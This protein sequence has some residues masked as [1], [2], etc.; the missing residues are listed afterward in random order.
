MD[1]NFFLHEMSLM[2]VLWMSHRY[3]KQIMVI[4]KEHE[5]E[6]Y[7]SQAIENPNTVMYSRECGVLKHF[8]VPGMTSHVHL[9]KGDSMKVGNTFWP[10]LVM[11]MIFYSCDRYK[12]SKC[13][14]AMWILTCSKKTNCGELCC[15]SNGIFLKK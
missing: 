15:V 4:W 12:P 8:N 2:H 6:L 10:N 1:L 3:L 5:H 7:D 13:I 11:K 14:Y 9:L